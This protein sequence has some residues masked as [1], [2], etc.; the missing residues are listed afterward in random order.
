M[1]SRVTDGHFR[2]TSDGLTVSSVGL[3]TIMGPPDDATDAAYQA[4]VE[5]ALVQGCNVI[6]TAINARY[7]RSER[8]IGRGRGAAVKRGG[9]PRDALARYPRRERMRPTAQRLM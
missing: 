6:D 3:G 1:G 4:A 9:H 5:R 7:Q 8:A 2:L